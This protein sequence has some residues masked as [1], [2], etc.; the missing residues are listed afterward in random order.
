MDEAGQIYVADSGNHRVIRMDDMTG[1][2]WTPLLS[3]GAGYPIGVF[4]DEACRI[5]MI[6]SGDSRIVRV[7][8]ITGTG[9]TTLVLPSGLPGFYSHPIGN[10]TGIFVDR[11][12]RIY[13]VAGVPWGRWGRSN[14]LVVRVTVRGQGT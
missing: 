13:V 2:G 7:D 14:G 3:Y 5:Y 12:G 9:W 8:D 1:A 10:P 11:A 6:D 4:G